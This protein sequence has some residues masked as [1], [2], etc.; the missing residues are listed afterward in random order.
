MKE[1]Q[2]F[3]QLFK[4]CPKR[5]L[6][7]GVERECLLC[8]NSGK[9][10]PIASKVLESLK[11]PKL[12]RFSFGSGEEFEWYLPKCFGYELSACQ[13]ESRVGPC[14]LACLMRKLQKLE[15]ILKESERELKFRRSFNE[16]GPANMPLDVFPDP[17]GR[18]QEITKNM[19]KHIL[20]AACRVIATHVHIGM[21]DHATALRVYNEVIK[22]L[23]ILCRS[24]DKSN[25]QRLAIYKV[26]APDYE[27]PFYES[28]EQFYREA[29]EKNFVTD[30]RKCWHLIRLSVH[31]TIEFRMFGATSDL[32][33]IV[34]WATACHHLCK[35]AMQ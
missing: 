29:V 15:Q 18:Y 5:S 7:V 8:N 32:D 21:P 11:K 33:E 26:M 17:T 10:V 3:L 35:K 28:W 4:F 13:L 20:L 22:Y 30:P 31:G 34:D 25:G 23:P 1:I 6:F 2:K 16:V 9:I 14:T 12:I 27:P 24:G 19:P